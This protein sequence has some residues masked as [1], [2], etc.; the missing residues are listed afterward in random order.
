MALMLSTSLRLE[1]VR[2]SF[3]GLPAATPDHPFVPQA[4]AIPVIRSHLHQGHGLFAGQRARF[5]QLSHDGWGN[6][7]ADPG[8]AW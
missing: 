4:A 6:D 2:A 5:R 3:L 7:R 8:D 1:A